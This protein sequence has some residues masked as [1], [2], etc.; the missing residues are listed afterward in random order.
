V[1]YASSPLLLVILS[2]SLAAAPHAVLQTDGGAEQEAFLVQLTG[3]PT[4]ATIT[5]GGRGGPC[6]YSGRGSYR[7]DDAGDLGIEAE[8]DCGGIANRTT[9]PVCRFS[10]SLECSSSARFQ[11]TYRI[12][13]AG[14]QADSR[15]IAWRP[16]PATSVPALLQALRDRIQAGAALERAEHPRALPNTTGLE[17]TCRSPR[18]TFTIRSNLS[19]LMRYQQRPDPEGLCDDQVLI[20][21]LGSAHRG[22]PVSPASTLGR[23]LQQSGKVTDWHVTRCEVAGQ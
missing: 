6:H 11:H 13:N 20:G 9:L 16:V 14:L 23:C 18:A 7:V 10:V 12:T 2:G 5:M 22:D 4:G 17:V 15:L 21:F 19:G 1:R 8:E 3:K